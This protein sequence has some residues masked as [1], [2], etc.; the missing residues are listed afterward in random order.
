MSRLAQSVQWHI[1]EACPNR[2]KHCYISNSSNDSRRLQELGFLDFVQILDNLSMFEQRYDVSINNFAL[3][4]GDPFV[5]EDFENLLAELSRRGKSIRILG[6]PERITP[7]N[8]QLMQRYNVQMYQVSLDGMQETHDAIRGPGSFI[9]TIEAIR[10][11]NEVSDIAPNVMFTLHSGNYQELFELI[12]YLDSLNMEISFS[13]DFLVFEGQAQK[14]FGL[15]PQEVIADIFTRYRQENL[16]LRAAGRKLVLREKVKLFETFDITD[17][18][19]IFEKYS[20]IGGC[21]C[22]ISSI[23]ILPN[24]DLYPCRRLPIVI[25]NL[26]HDDYADLFL[27]HPIMRKLRRISSFSYCKN[28]DFAKLCRGCPALAYSIFRDPFEKMPYCVYKKET[29]LT[30]SEPSLDC[31]AEEEFAYLTNDLASHFKRDGFLENRPAVLHDIYKRLFI[32]SNSTKAGST[33][34]L[35]EKASSLNP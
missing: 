12:C 8:I 30:S 7:H 6:I 25:G 20:L 16:R 33:S 15:L 34:A 29:S 22:G 21:S 27:N 2:C 4:G 18:S 32:L 23:T 17:A 19:K 9:R 10:K 24:G 13:F 28:C 14:G 31:S 5:H 1:T 26:L 35:Q 3:T 11:L